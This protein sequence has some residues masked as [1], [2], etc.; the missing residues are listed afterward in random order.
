MEV[1]SV[2]TTAM[3]LGLFFLIS[4]VAAEDPYKF[5]EWHVTYGNISPLKV[6]QQVIYL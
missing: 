5:F 3:I 1:K 2:N 4:F 6:A